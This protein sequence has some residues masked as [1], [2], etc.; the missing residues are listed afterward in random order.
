MRLLR[1]WG[2]VN[3]IFL[4]IGACKKTLVP[5]S[6]PKL[7]QTTLILTKPKPT[8]PLSPISLLTPHHLHATLP[9]MDRTSQHTATHR[10]P[11]LNQNIS[12]VLSFPVAA[13]THKLGIHQTQLHLQFS[14]F[15]IKLHSLH[16]LLKIQNW[17]LDVYTY[18][19]KHNMSHSWRMHLKP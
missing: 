12:G 5:S 9:C 19:Y 2:T 15:Q 4:Q 1:N 6:S 7:S 11:P 14:S 3:N 16:F 13:P 8:K 17:P 10:H 18:I